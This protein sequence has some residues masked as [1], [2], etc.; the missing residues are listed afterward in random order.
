MCL[1]FA[2]SLSQWAILLLQSNPLFL[3]TF[4]LWIHNSRYCWWRFTNQRDHHKKK[5]EVKLTKIN[6]VAIFI[7]TYIHTYMRQG[8]QSFLVQLRTCH[9]CCVNPLPEPMLTYCPECLSMKFNLKFIAFHSTKY[10]WH[11]CMQNVDHFVQG[12]IV[13]AIFHTQFKFYG[14]FALQ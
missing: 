10:K 12:P 7:K 8:M 1:P 11:C 4:H 5:E 9:L 13:Q 2:C 3:Q 14:N 6:K